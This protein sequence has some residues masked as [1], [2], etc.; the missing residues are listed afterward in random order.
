MNIVSDI[1]GY[2]S[3][4]L[5]QRCLIFK[6]INILHDGKTNGRVKEIESERETQRERR[7]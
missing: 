4:A 3:K 7:R 2:R 5:M 6:S 1:N